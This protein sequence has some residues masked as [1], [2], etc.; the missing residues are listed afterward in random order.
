MR[1]PSS[2]G[3]W[4]FETT[5][6][7]HGIAALQQP[8]CTGGARA[9]SEG[10]RRQV[11]E[12]CLCFLQM[13]KTHVSTLEW[14]LAWEKGSYELVKVISLSNPWPFVNVNHTCQFNTLSALLELVCFAVQKVLAQQLKL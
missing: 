14:L 2:D 9:S 3:S 13:L 5:A 11:R 1:A 8:T 4:I 7:L 12:S 6:S 10:S